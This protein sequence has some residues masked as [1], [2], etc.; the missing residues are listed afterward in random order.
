M[1]S[2]SVS[3]TQ[4]SLSVPVCLPVCLSV[5]GWGGDI[6]ER[7]RRLAAHWRDADWTLASYVA[8]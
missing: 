1:N 7:D 2:M 8:R 5:K 6:K 4:L 3:K